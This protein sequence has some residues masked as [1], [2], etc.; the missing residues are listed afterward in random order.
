MA[1][2]GQ[3]LPIGF[4]LASYNVC[5]T[6][7]ADIR[8]QRNIRRDGPGTDIAKSQQAPRPIQRR[9]AARSVVAALV[10]NGCR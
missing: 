2:V 10:T 1:V 4:V 3:S 8:F 6:P 7:K 9:Q 5:S